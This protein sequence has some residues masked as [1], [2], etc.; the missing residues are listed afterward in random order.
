M[1]KSEAEQ[2]GEQLTILCGLAQWRQITI[3]NLATAGVRVLVEGREAA[4]VDVNE[5]TLLESLNKAVK[6]LRGF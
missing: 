4:T 1:A 2:V 5:F 3:V 6:E